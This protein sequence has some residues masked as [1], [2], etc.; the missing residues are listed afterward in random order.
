DMD[1]EAPPEVLQA[2]R[3]RAEHGIFGY[4]VRTDDYYDAVINWMRRR[5]AWEVKQS[6]ITFTPGVVPAL[7]FAI[8]AFTNPGDKVIIQPPVYYPFMNAVI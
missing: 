7:N 2:I 1:F 8:K 6:W 4:S 3:Q 5:F